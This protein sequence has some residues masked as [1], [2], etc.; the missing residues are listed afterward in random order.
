M[1][2]IKTSLLNGIAVVVKM[3]SLLVLNK[4]LALYVGPSG[5][6]AIGQFQNAIQMIMALTSGSIG[7]GVTKY[8]AEYYESEEKQHTL[9]Q[10]ASTIAFI[11]TLIISLL[12]VLFN[13]QLAAWFLKDETY[14]GVF[15]CFA[16]TLLLFVFNILLLAVLN[17]KKEIGSYIVANIAGSIISILLTGFMVIYYGLYGALIALAINQSFTFFVTFYITSRSSWFKVRYFIGSIDKAVVK[18]LSKYAAMAITGAICAPICNILVRNYIGENLGWESAGYWES[19]VRI[20]GAYLMV[21]TTTLGV[22]FLPKFSELSA[23]FDIRS[24]ITKSLVIVLPLLFL[25]LSVIYIFKN[26]VVGI[27]MSKEFLPV[28]DLFHWYLIG[29]FIKIV[30]WFFAFLMIS[31]SMTKAYIFSEIFSSTLFYFLSIYFT[32]SYGLVGV[33]I[34]HF[35]T[36]VV[37]L[38]IVFLVFCNMKS[39]GVFK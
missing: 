8:T 13:K 15:L 34:A 18:N 6:A 36:Y 19:M 26:E 23:Y 37:Y 22:Y 9:W 24:E 16:V 31:K 21:V 10:T 27:L 3:I 28:T 5:Y 25:M 1:T 35:L 14:G 12:V 33:S 20:S 4:V 38:I 39:S 2:F 11:S 30:S 17:G 29:D 7:T 32:D